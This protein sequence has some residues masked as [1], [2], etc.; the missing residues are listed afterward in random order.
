MRLQGPC[1]QP[2]C[3][4]RS[5]GHG[6]CQQ[7]EQQRKARLDGERGTAAQRGYGADWRRRRAEVLRETPSCQV[8][9]R[10]ATDVHHVARRSQAG[11]DGPLVALCHRCHSSVTSREVR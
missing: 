7:H 5:A 10:L 2:G 3:P 6:L 1:T 4:N 8:C 9:G 11:D